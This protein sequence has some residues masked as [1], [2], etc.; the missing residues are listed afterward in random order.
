MARKNPTITA[1]DRT[2]LPNGIEL[3]LAAGVSSEALADGNQMPDASMKPNDGDNPSIPDAPFAN[4]RDTRVPD[5]Q[6]GANAY[7]A[8]PGC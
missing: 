4:G 5:K 7:P 2:P 8:M 3:P 1:G 6:G